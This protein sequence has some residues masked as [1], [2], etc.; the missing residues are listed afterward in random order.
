MDLLGGAVDSTWKLLGIRDNTMGD[1][2][3]ASFNRPAI[4]NCIFVSSQV[5][6][7]LFLV[8]DVRLATHC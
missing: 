5:N 8:L 7:A 1:I 4:V 2:V 3:T 6:F